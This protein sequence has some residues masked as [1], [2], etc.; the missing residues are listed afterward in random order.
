MNEIDLL[1]DTDVLIEILRATQQAGEWL[2]SQESN[3]IGITVITRMEILQG[4]GSKREQRELANKLERF[5]TVQVEAGDSEQALKFF[6]GFR[7]SDG[8]SIMDLLIAS[9]ALHTEKPFYTF[10]MKHFRVI[11]GLNPQSPFN[12]KPS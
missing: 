12:R 7:L 9:I 11:P 2:E 8:L 5:T 6:E 4:A 1:I 3:I 10:N